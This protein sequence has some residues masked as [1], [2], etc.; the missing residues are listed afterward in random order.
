M[1]K[2]RITTRAA[3]A[4]GRRFQQK[5]AQTL[6][7]LLDLP[8]GKDELIASREMGQAGV[9]IRLIGEAKKRFPYAIEC[10]NQESWDIHAWI[11]QAR[12]NQGDFKSWLLFVTKNHF[13]DIVFMEQSVFVDIVK[14]V[15]TSICFQTSSYSQK[16]WFLF[17]WLQAIQ[18]KAR[19]AGE[20]WLLF[21]TRGNG[22]KVVV[23]E[24]AQFFKIMNSLILL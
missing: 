20:P 21:L 1:S 14:E 23:M 18:E 11:K 12:E 10:K 13:N 9:D 3:K 16:S 17:P 24:S 8:W 2:K 5:I 19:R 7:E 15:P 6:S 4:K 22:E